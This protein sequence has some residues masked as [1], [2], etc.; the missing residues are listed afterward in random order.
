MRQ[1]LLILL[2]LNFIF[3]FLGFGIWGLLATA[4]L[5]ALIYK[6]ASKQEFLARKGWDEKLAIIS[7]CVFCVIAVESKFHNPWFTFSAGMLEVL[8]FVTT[9]RAG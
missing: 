1:G 5:G 9:A 8:I 4:V 7:S 6:I 2:I 3:I